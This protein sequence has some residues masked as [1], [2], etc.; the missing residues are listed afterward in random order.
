MAEGAVVMVSST[1]EESRSGQEGMTISAL[2][3]KS[4]VT[5]KCQLAPWPRD[6]KVNIYN[7]YIIIRDIY[8]YV[9]MPAPQ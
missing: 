9:Y 7:R 8:A 3:Y 2:G 6:M 4:Y 5:I 1:S